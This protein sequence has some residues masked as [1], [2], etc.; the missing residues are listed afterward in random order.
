MAKDFHRPHAR[1]DLGRIQ[2]RIY[3]VEPGAEMISKNAKT[4]ELTQDGRACYRAGGTMRYTCCA[5]TS[6]PAS[7]QMT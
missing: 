3:P 7:V 2:Q 5:W 4:Y 6:M 1:E